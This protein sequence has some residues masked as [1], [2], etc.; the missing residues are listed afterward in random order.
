MNSVYRHKLYYLNPDV[1]VFRNGRVEII[2]TAEGNLNF[3]SYVASTPEGERLIGDAAKVQL[4]GNPRN[5][6]FNV[7]RLIG[8]K[9]RD[10]EVQ[11][12]IKTFPFEVIEK[13][14]KPCIKFGTDK[15]FAPEEISAII[16]AKIKETAETYQDQKITHAVI[17]VPAYFN[18][19][20]RQATIDAGV[21]A[22]LIV[23]R[24]INEPTAAV[25]AYGLDK[26]GGEKNILVFDLGGGKLDV[27]V[28]CIDHGVV[29]KVVST[30]GDTHLGGEDFDQRVI[31]HFIQLYKDKGKDVRRDD[32]KVQKL[33]RE[34]ERATRTLS[35]TE[36]ILIEVESFFN[37]EDFSATLTR[38]EFEKLN[39]DLFLSMITRIRKALQDANMRKD[40]IAE[41]LLVGGASRMPKIWEL[42]KDFFNGKEPIRGIHPD[43][44]VV[45]GLAFC[46]VTLLLGRYSDELDTGYFVFLD[47]NPFA[48]GI[49][50][51]GGSM[52]RIILRNTLIPVKKSKSFT[53]SSKDPGVILVYEGDSQIAKE[54]HFLGRFDIPAAEKVGEEREIED[55]A[56]AH[57][58]NA[59]TRFLDKRSLII[60]RKWL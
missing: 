1:G 14:E 41:I 58:S 25:I 4:T 35:S 53:T 24:L 59:T 51:V 15:S 5:T 38:A 26:H 12:D 6:V 3:P 48:L 34:V 22:G 8:R 36:A 23:T 46:A 11:A 40:D 60:L 37:G 39:M 54:N 18:D 21:I 49:E 33:R 50:T 30:N 57:A 27:S 16:L 9:W 52:S 19:A 47:V 32:P 13:N 7:K 20:Q 28:V 10:P 56:L 2:P 43:L 45:N 31:D 55:G 17:S 44:A 42:V 29:F